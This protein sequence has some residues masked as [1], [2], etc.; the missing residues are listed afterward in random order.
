LDTFRSSVTAVA[1]ASA[2]VCLTESLVSGT[3]LRK[4]MKLLLD[5]VLAMVMLIPFANGSMALE[6][7][8]IS[9]IPQPESN[10]ALELY[11]E[12]LSRN[13]AE[14]VGAVLYEQLAAAG[15]SCESLDID[16]NISADGSISISRVTVIAEDFSAARSVITGCLGSGTEVVDGSG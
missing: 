11:N 14:N 1:V 7:P 15:I 10:Y 2:A 5:T 13:A 4:Q 6:M 16:V 12:S 3:R 9:E 8:E